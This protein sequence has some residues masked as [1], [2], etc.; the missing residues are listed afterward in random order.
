MPLPIQRHG[1]MTRYSLQQAAILVD[2]FTYMIYFPLSSEDGSISSASM[3]YYAKNQRGFEFFTASVCYGWRSSANHGLTVDI[4]ISRL[5]Y[6]YCRVEK[7]LSVWWQTSDGCS[8]CCVLCAVCCVL[9]DRCVLCAVCCVLCAV[10]CVLCAVCCVL[11]AVC[12]VLRSARN[13]NKNRNR[14]GVFPHL[15]SAAQS[16]TADVRGGN[17]P[18]LFHTSRTALLW[19]FQLPLSDLLLLSA[20]RSWLLS[21]PNA[22]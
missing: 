18:S 4:P 21:R 14:N 5:T 9:C 7:L 1:M 6:M 3:H 17:Y 10:C 20:S 12:Y 8:V 15:K 2:T 22:G 13:R 16:G 11:W 19:K